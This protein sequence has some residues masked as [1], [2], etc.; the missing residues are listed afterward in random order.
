MA[1]SITAT[2][3]CDRCGR[4]CCLALEPQ[5][6]HMEGVYAVATIRESYIP[7]GWHVCAR[8]MYCWACVEP[9]PERPRLWDPK[10]LK[11]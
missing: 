2:F 3:T 10:P 1:L 7:N 9:L 4:R 11:E 5:L 8:G 6:W